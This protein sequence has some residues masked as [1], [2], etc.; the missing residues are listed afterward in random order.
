MTR[1]SPSSE[2][3]AD[4]VLLPFPDLGQERSARLTRTPAGMALLGGECVQCARRF[5]PRRSACP[6]CAATRIRDR[7]LADRGTLYSYS[8]VHVSSARSTPY[9]IGYVDLD[10]DVRLLADIVAGEVA[11]R[12]DMPVRLQVA[13]D[14]R[15]C[16]VPDVQP[17][18]GA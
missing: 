11:L 1:T 4:R 14:G 12:V 3:S 10:R 18:V 7:P 2:A 16:F 5:F 8:V 6:A 9:T 17:G 15:W 13:E